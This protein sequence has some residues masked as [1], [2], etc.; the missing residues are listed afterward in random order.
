M[1]CARIAPGLVVT[2]EL[3]GHDGQF[4]AVRL[5]EVSFGGVPV[6]VPGTYYLPAGQ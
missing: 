1:T 6:C 4:A 3:L 5:E 2:G